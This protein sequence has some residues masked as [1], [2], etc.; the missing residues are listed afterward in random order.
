M[1]P[2]D[3]EIDI[4]LFSRNL[5]HAEKYQDRFIDHYLEQFRIYVHIMNSTNDRR[6]RSNEFFLGLNAAII[7]VLGYV[8]VKNISDAPLIF[9][10]IPF[11]GMGICYSWYRII[12]SYRQISKAKYAVIHEVEKKLPASLFKSEWEILGEKRKYKKYLP[13]SH[14]ENLIPVIFILFYILVLFI[15]IPWMSILDFFKLN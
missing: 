9:I 1:E 5:E 3:K 13:I 10:L 8:E 15:N 14:I 2:K 11:I 4:L 7:G 6:H 12:I